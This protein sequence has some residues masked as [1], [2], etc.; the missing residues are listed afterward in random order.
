MDDPPVGFE[1]KKWLALKSALGPALQ[2]VSE[3]MSF[4]LLLYPFDE[5]EPI[6]LDCFDDCCSV[7]SGPAAVQVDIQGGM[8]SVPE[9]LAALDDAEPGGGTPTAD[10]LAAALD[11]FTLGAGQA[12]KGD[13]YV[14]LAT[15]GGPNC[16]RDNECDADHCT[17]NLDGLCSAGNC[18]E[19]EG[20][21]CLDDEAVVTQLEALAQAG[22]STFVVGIPGTEKYASYL[23]AFA[24]AGGVTNPNGPPDYYAVSAEGGVDAL[25]QTFVDITTHL[26]RSCDV[27][28]GSVA[29]DKT[30]L[31]VAV[32]CEIVPFEDGAGWDI[33]P[34]TPTTLQ[35]AGD[36]CKR[37]KRQGA[38]RVDEVYRSPPEKRGT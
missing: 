35:L 36:T 31:N 26:V 30:L 20:Q 37:L 28:L 13:K 2:Q 38:R 33:D 8:C 25:T 23:D 15:D 6:P 10:A 3:E 14:L 27:D 34:E 18:C 22:V 11:Y 9:V 7:E 29:P 19:G 24:A 16:A 17:P 21:F 12:K 4:G 5:K 1:Q 32:D